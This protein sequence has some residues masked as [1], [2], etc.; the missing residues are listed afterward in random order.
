MEHVFSQG[1]LVLLYMHN[2]LTSKSTHALVCL[3]D[4]SACGL[5]KDCNIKTMAVLLDVLGE[6]EPKFQQGW[7]NLGRQV[8]RHHI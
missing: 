8:D 4:W 1:H 7:E 3:G 5:V 2:C 6:Q